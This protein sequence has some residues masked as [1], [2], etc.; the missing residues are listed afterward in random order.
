MNQYPNL[1]RKLDLGF[2]ELRNRI[3][4]GSMHTGLEEV[5]DWRR[6]AEFYKTRALGE[7]GLIVTGGI[8]P[9]LEGS[10]LPGAAMM[11]SEKD[12]ENHSVVTKAVHNA[13]GKIAMQILH[14]GRY[15]YSDKAVAPS[16]LKAPISPFIP[17]ELDEEGIENQ[18]SDIARSAHLAKA[19]GYDGVEIMGS[20]GY[21]INQFLVRHT[22]K[23][24]D[25]WGGSYENRIRFPLEVVKRIRK[26]VG[27]DYLIIYRLSLIDL[28]PDGSSWAEVVYLAKKMESVGVNIIN[29]GIGWHEARIP[30]IA[31]SVPK[32][33]FSW[34][35]KK[36][37]GEV[38][39]PII[40][41]N[42]I[43]SPEIA[44]SIL[45]EQC[46]DLVSLA[47]PFL[48]DPDFARKSA[49][50]K[51]KEIVPCIACN[52]A[53]LDHTFSMKLTS[54]LVN[55]RACHETEL[56]YHRVK[57]P[58]KIAVVGAGPAG[59]SFSITAAQRGHNITLFESKTEI[60]GQLNF[61]KMIPGKEEFYGLL[62]YYDNEINR[63]GV[64]LRVGFRANRTDLLN[65]DEIVLATGVNPK[66]TNIP[67]QK[68]AKNVISYQDVFENKVK[69][70]KKVAI[71]GA[72]GI[73]FDV[74]EYLS[75]KGKSPTLDLHKWLRE[76]G[77]VDPELQRGGLSQEIEPEDITTN[78][79]IFLLQRRNE[80]LGKRLGKTTGWI[81][82]KSLTKKGVKM[83][84]GVNYEKVVPEGL[85]ISLGNDQEGKLLKVDTIIICAGQESENEL[86][87]TLIESKLDFQIIGGAAIAQKLDAKL[88][89]DQGCRLAAQI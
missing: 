23:R 60:G 22:N 19:A 75:S 42:R 31:T 14:A 51:G 3:I 56:V 39:I 58:K 16:S 30:T 81:H 36:L 13:G 29:S 20:E 86:E 15:A 18:I 38:S 24:E 70:G 26:E 55:P 25:R 48:A 33:A 32:R 37:Y 84:A 73:G 79:E 68:F 63:L 54:C 49:Q 82:R 74:A 57:N 46:A 11:V 65:F 66:N 4:M 10:V 27:K 62:E 61:A 85:V 7:V 67:G 2:L 28:I 5:G 43:N 41:S 6:V 64:R 71:V 45:E 78:R 87:K 9:N 17:S 8:G 77:V 52:Q 80:R 76:W 59:I 47:R 35:T 1:F 40:A 89:I 83:I 34:V 69:I 44:E 88:A 50:G 21:L 72:G 12:V 53:C